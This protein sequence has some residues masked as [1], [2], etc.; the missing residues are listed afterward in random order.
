[1]RFAD[2][3]VVDEA[4]SPEHSTSLDRASS[5]GTRGLVHYGFVDL[6]I[7]KELFRVQHG[8]H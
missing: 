6:V 5:F 7:E 8:P 1:M 4:T 2:A 3:I